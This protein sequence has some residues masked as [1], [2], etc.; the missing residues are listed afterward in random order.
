[1]ITLA[2]LLAACTTP[3]KDDLEQVA[4]KARTD[5]KGGLFGAARL[6]KVCPEKI[7]QQVVVPKELAPDSEG[8]FDKLIPAI[9]RA[10]ERTASKRPPSFYEE[11][12]TGDKDEPEN[13]D[14]E[15]VAVSIQDLIPAFAEKLGFSYLVD[16][17]VAGAVT[18]HVRQAKMTR[19]EIWQLF[20]QML[21]LS[22]AYCST[23]G[24]VLRIMPFARMPQERRIFASTQPANVEVMI[25]K[26]CNV[27]AK[28]LID[29]IQPF[30]TEGSRATE[31][32][33]E[34][35]IMLVESPENMPKLD[36][37]IKVL[38]RKQRA[39]WPK[40]AIRCVNVPST[41]I[42]EELAAV[43][44]VLGFA[45]ATDKV[46]A[47]PGSIHL[48]NIDRLE[49]IVASAANQEALDELKKWAAILDRADIGEQERVF[50]YKVIN[51][52]AEELLQAL[53]VLFS[54]EGTAMAATSSS[55][56]GT[57]GSATAEEGGSGTRGASSPRSTTSTSNVSS[58]NG[59]SGQAAPANI[60]EVPVKI[61]A[62]GKHNRMVIR[63]TPRTYAM[64]KAVLETLDTVP[65][66]VLLQVLIA[67]IRLADNSEFGLEYYAKA[68][69]GDSYRS[70]IGYDSNMGADASGSLSDTD[71]SGFKYMLF[72]K[73]DDGKY[74]YLRAAASTSN[75][76]ILSSPQLA[77]VSGTA[78]SIDIAEDVPT[79]TK[80]VSDTSSGA[81]STS[82]EVQYRKTGILLKVTP[83]VTKGGLI[84]MEISQEVSERGED[85][86]AG[87]STY[88]SFIDREMITALSL[89]DG[90]TIIVGGIIQE[91]NRQSSN[92]LPFIAKVP[93]LASLFGQNTHAVD[94]TELLIMITA[95]IISEATDLEKV[96]Q[97][98]KKSVAA[99]KEFEEKN[100]EE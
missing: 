66:Q 17:K 10:E 55:T 20:E 71:G 78:A 6:H 22:G 3:E 30:L 34:N 59:T 76:K 27:P 75:F 77:A 31:L 42:K 87:G 25:V 70:L 58:R 90:G 13:F 51:S 60:F 11:W 83:H 86:S 68:S 91:R 72:N 14:I 47:E 37:L 81:T 84:T 43:L 67:E 64:V 85:V 61:F 16:P 2:A 94:R 38:D 88:P 7:D 95:N 73:N 41:R 57:G 63:T 28:S 97:R 62:D 32:A 23:E 45:V 21:W 35:A 96:I 53:T 48:S 9:E 79:I 50:V 74:A 65:A 98:Y 80:T 93:L 29:K 92:S 44:P 15:L 56:G 19:R 99:I 39:T 49:V 100:T 89:R 1:M 46:E 5:E 54:I 8:G 40:T 18:L 24:G 69:S 52:T 4:E 33:G 26:I 36:A 12:L 82:N